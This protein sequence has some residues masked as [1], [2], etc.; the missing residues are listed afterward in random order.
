MQ[1][2][3][4]N[5]SLLIGLVIGTLVC[6]GAVY[7]IWRFQIE[8]KS[9]ALLVEAEKARK[10]GDYREEV[11]YYWQYLTLNRGDD[12]AR[13]KYAK[14]YADLAEQE[15]A[16]FQDINAAWQQL[17]NTV[18]DRRLAARP[19]A[20]E[21]RR[22][23]AEIFGRVGRYQDALDHLGTLIENDPKDTELRV[24][25]VAYLIQANDSE[26][27][28]DEAYKLIGYDPEA[29]TFD[30]AKA[31]APREV[32]VYA[33]L[34]GLLRVKQEAPELADRVMAQL[35]EVNPESADA[36][37]AR[38]LYRLTTEDKEGAKADIEK[39]YDLKPEDAGVLVNIA[40]IAAQNEE[41]DKAREYVEAG[42]KLFPKDERFYRVGADI[43][44][45]RKDYK[46]GLAEI[47]QGLKAIGDKISMLMIVKADFQFNAREVDALRRTIEDMKRAGFPPEFPEWFEAKILVLEE[48][49]QAAVEALG[50]LKPRLVNAPRFGLNVVEADYFLGLSNERLGRHDLA[51]DYYEMVVAANPEHELGKL[52][53]ARVGAM[54]GRDAEPS[55]ELEQELNEMLK[56]PKEQQD[57]PALQ[58]KVREFAKEKKMDEPSLKVF[59]AQLMMSREDYDGAAKALAEANKLKP[60][61]LLITRVYVQ[62]F[63]LNPKAGPEKALE[64]WQKMANQFKD[65][66]DALAELR[67]D[68]A[69]ILIAMKKDDLRAELAGLSEGIDN[70]PAQ[71]KVELWG[72]MSQKYLTLG[73]MDEA[74]QYLSLAADNRPNELPLRMSLFMLAL[75]AGDDAG[76]QEAQKKILEIVKDRN[77]SNWL[78]TEARRKLSQLQRGE[79]GKEAINEIRQL[80]NRAQEQRPDWHEPYVVSAELELQAE[81]YAQSLRQYDEAAK[82]GRLYPRAVAQHIRLLYGFGRYAEAGQQMERL[83]EPHRQ[84][85]L[86]ALYPEILFLTKKREDALKEARAATERDPENPQTHY[87]YGQLLFRVARQAELTDE[88]RK[89]SLDKAIEAMRRVVDLQPEF[90]DAW[91]ALITYYLTLRDDDQAQKALR[92]AQL[93]LNGDNLQLFLAKSYEALRR[94]F[95]AETMY[96]AVYEAKPGELPRAQQLAAFYLGPVYPMPDR[97]QKAA[98]LLNQILRA[99]AEGKIAANDPSVQWARRMGARL[100]AAEARATGDY[101]SL[102]K[103]EKLLTSNQQAGIFSVEDK[104]EMARILHTR[105]EPE[106]RMKARDYLEDVRESQAQALGEEEELILAELYY[107]LGDW[108]R[109]ISQMDI[110]TNRYSESPRAREAYARRLLARGDQQSI[111]KAKAHI[112]KL[113]Q[114][115][116]NSAASF[117]LAVRL[118][119]KL[120]M[121]PQARAEL[122]RQ[123]PD[124][125][126]IQEINSQ[127]LRTLLMF[128]DLFVELDDLDTAEKIYTQLAAREPAMSYALAVFLGTHRGVD[129][130]FEK[131]NEIYQ[132][133]RIPDILRA[134]LDVVRKK[135]DQVAEQY[136]PQIERWLEIGLLESPDSISLQMLK[137]DFRDIQRNYDEAAALY[138][139]L[140]DHKD[141]VGLRRAIVLNNLAYLIALAGPAAGSDVDA[142]KLVN[143]AASILGPNSDILDTR[144]I[145]YIARGQY[146]QAIADLELSVTDNPTASKYFHKALAH[147]LARENREAVEAWEKAEGLGLSRE[148]VNRMEYEKYDETKAKID[149]L[150]GGAPVTQTEP[151]RRAG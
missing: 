89:Q 58:A 101:Q 20:K 79:V 113:R 5:F 134:A 72:G 33:N 115:A 147:L 62:L 59:E 132:P 117:E 45:R 122:L 47:D 128:A 94:W 131:L 73:M 148:S 34:A 42:K 57:W 35:I 123:L 81:N 66:E 145:V 38:A 65:R 60:N 2:Y 98:P 104:L 116:P 30:A 80:V 19:E 37:L 107:A 138:R 6:S 75:D 55:S 91:Y 140:L 17:E 100:L 108:R 4:V 3:R 16:T 82:R 76:M 31:T 1:Q 14:A 141:L 87:I 21:L 27:A 8:R 102:V 54:A 103:A 29:D 126:A 112:T 105:P 118:F 26:K 124:I 69:D 71:E 41:Y 52:G 7:G 136:D 130:A 129:K 83:S 13:M 25:R 151:L 86:G 44:I 50:R 135:R 143:E 28:I 15:D 106:S 90:P 11:K 133:D 121:Q 9:G 99:G 12:D 56:K 96:R 144:A 23:L 22:S 48:K 43:E 95:D 150:R 24:L 18:R 92:D 84:T 77:D 120:D 111:N 149:E 93:A 39:A 53:R 139:K 125:A 109:Y 119:D 67:L 97:Q 68:K 64:M 10:A 70:W 137:A 32:D 146:S 88:E 142:L 74:R 36:Y 78:F 127:Q 63:R 46:A 85:L 110:V 40:I 61:D 114:L 49:W 51:Y